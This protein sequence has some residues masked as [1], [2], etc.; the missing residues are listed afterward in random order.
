MDKFVYVESDPPLHGIERK[1]DYHRQ[2]HRWRQANLPEYRE[3]HR[4]NALRHYY[5]TPGYKERIAASNKRRWA[6][7]VKR[8]RL[9]EQMRQSNAR[10]RAARNAAITPDSHPSTTN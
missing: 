10:R 3:R 6:D 7:P 4:A 2:A 5:N 9:K 8:E 1:R